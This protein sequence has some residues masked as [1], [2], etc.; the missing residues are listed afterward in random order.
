MKIIAVK[1]IS[2]RIFEP[3][4]SAPKYPLLFTLYP[5]PIALSLR[6]VIECDVNESF[7]LDFC[8][9]TLRQIKHFTLKK[10]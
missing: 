2:K 4:F 7:A 6:Y 10:F 9:Y 8:S 3:L 1:R 5:F